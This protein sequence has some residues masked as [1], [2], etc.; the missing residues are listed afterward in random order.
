MIKECK[1]CFATEADHN[2]CFGCYMKE[3]SPYLHPYNHC[4]YCAHYPGS[5]SCD[6]CPNAPAEEAEV[7]TVGENDDGHIAFSKCDGNCNSCEQYDAIHNTCKEVV[8]AMEERKTALILLEHKIEAEL[9]SE[10]EECADKGDACFTC[11]SF[12]TEELKCSLWD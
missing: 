2:I 12:D 4:D 8:L 1:E 7:T 9:K 6:Y 10:Y 11:G 5:K 3:S